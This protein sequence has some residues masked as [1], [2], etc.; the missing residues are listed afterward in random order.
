[1]D[2]IVIAHLVRDEQDKA[3][4]RIQ[5]VGEYRDAHIAEEIKPKCR[6]LLTYGVSGSDADLSKRSKFRPNLIDHAAVCVQ[7]VDIDEQGP[8]LV[9]TGAE[10]IGQVSVYDMVVWHDEG[11]NL[12][13]DG[14]IAVDEDVSAVKPED[15][16]AQIAVEKASAGTEK[17][18]EEA[19]GSLIV[20]LIIGVIF[21]LIAGAAF[22]GAMLD[23]MDNALLLMAMGAGVAV[24]Y[25]A[26]AI[27][28]FKLRLPSA[29]KVFYLLGSAALAMTVLVCE[30]LAFSS[31]ADDV[32]PALIL[33][34]LIVFV[35]SLLG[36]FKLYQSAAFNIIA[37]L[38]GYGLLLSI[39]NT[40]EVKLDS[41]LYHTLFNGNTDDGVFT[42]SLAAVV[43]AIVLSYVMLKR[44]V[45]P[46]ISLVFPVLACIVS[47]VSLLCEKESHFDILSV[48]IYAL[49]ASFVLALRKYPGVFLM[50]TIWGV[51]IGVV[52]D[53]EG[54]YP[55]LL[56]GVC[57]LVSTSMCYGVPV[58]GKTFTP[59]VHHKAYWICLVGILISM[60]FAFDEYDHSVLVYIIPALATMGIGIKYHLTRYIVAFG[61]ILLFVGMIEFQDY[62]ESVSWWIYMLVIGAI[63]ISFAIVNEVKHR[64]GQSL[65]QKI[66]G[67]KNSV[68][69]W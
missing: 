31:G 36:Y 59:A 47:W 9:V 1:M 58:W 65:V 57:A 18:G 24:F 20:P 66:R 3:H 53:F 63:L 34:F 60:L 7:A 15:V 35:A 49:L 5:F 68:W 30:V 37:W 6:L 32:V 51:M 62:L 38:S 29:S 64:R 2:L 39:A 67:I 33:P 17:N 4:A 8:V 27:S 11:Q 12:S 14:K 22:V 43:C 26:F 61:M 28:Q 55:L 21:I 44:R 45:F 69:K 23:D 48:Y 52:Y 16:Q 56:S 50:L 41:S 42:F 19:K 54:E 25:G 40:I 46:K 10:D 13:D